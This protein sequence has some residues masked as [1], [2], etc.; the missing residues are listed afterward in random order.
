MIRTIISIVITFALITTLSAYEMWYVH[1]TFDLFHE[2]LV[3]LREKAEN[4]TV[5]VEDGRAIQIF[6]DKKKESLHVWLP[7]TA[8]QEVDYQLD[9]AVGFIHTQ[10]YDDAI[11]KIEVLIG[12]SEHIPMSYTF[13]IQ[14]IF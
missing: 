10:S 11:P 6:W 14:N 3:S 12:L 5:T 8:L 9:E 4:K 7:H 13:G 2:A 1:T